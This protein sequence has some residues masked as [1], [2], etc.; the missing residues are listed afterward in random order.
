MGM[1]PY[2]AWIIFWQVMA[3]AWNPFAPPPKRKADR[4]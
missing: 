4:E 3:Q 2:T 1:N